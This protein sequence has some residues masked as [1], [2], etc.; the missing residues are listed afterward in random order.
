MPVEVR[1]P[2][3]SERGVDPRPREGISPGSRSS[4]S[5]APDVVPAPPA[6]VGD[7][8]VPVQGAP[9]AAELEAAMDKAMAKGDS[10]RR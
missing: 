7:K 4:P 9:G 3:S 5:R 2:W 10:R 1:S 8:P 6:R